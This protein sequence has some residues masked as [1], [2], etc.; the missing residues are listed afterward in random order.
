MSW[1]NFDLADPIACIEM[2]VCYQT[3]IGLGLYLDID[4]I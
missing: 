3:F 4:S 2:Y 1:E